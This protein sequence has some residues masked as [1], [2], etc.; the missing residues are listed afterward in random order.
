MTIVNGDVELAKILGVKPS[1]IRGWRKAGV[2]PHTRIG[3]RGVI[4]F[5]ED[6]IAALRKQA[7]TAPAK[8]EKK[9]ACAA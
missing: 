6:V 5:K 7:T 1:R 2:L 3:E 4:Y 9:E 8:K